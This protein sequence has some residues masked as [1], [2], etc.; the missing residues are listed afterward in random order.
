MGSRYKHLFTPIRIRGIDL[1]NRIIMAPPSPNVA[2]HEGLVTRDF[3]D[4]MRP[5]ARGGAAVIY[6]GNASIDR[7]ECFDEDY[8]LDLREDKSILPLSWYAEMAAQYGCHASLEINHNGK[9]TAPEAIGRPPISASPIITASEISRAK[10]LGRDPIPAIEMTHEKIAETVEKYAMAA[11]RMQ[12][13]GMNICLVHGGHGNL[14]SQFTSP[15]YNKRTDEYGG[16]LE[17]RA[18]FAIEVCKAIR[19]KCGPNF[20]ID[21]RIS[22]DEIAPEGMHFPETLELIG[23]LKDYIDMLN[24][25]AGL[26]SDF[27]FKYYRNW[28]QN[29]MMERGYNV[30]YARKIKERYPDLLVTAVGSIVSIDMVEEIIGNGWA[31][32]VA[33][34]RPLMADPEM[35]RKYALGRPEDRR[36]CLRCDACAGRLF[37]SRPLNCAVN[38]Y[39]GMVFEF[40]DGRVPKAPVKK[41]V[42]VVGGGPAGIQAMLALCERGHDVTLY[43]KS[44]KLG[45]NL[46]GAAVPSFKID[47]Q[48]YRDWLLRQAEKAPARIL[49]NTEATKEILEK[50]DYDAIIIAVGAKPVIPDVPGIDKPHVHWAPDAHLGKA[51]VGEKIAIIGAGAIGVETAIDFKQDGKDVFLIEIQGPETHFFSLRQSAGNVSTEQMTYIE[52]L[53]IPLHYETRLEEVC[54]DK[55]ICRNV[56]TGETV[57]YPCDTVLLAVGMV[58]LYDVVDSLRRCAPETEVHIVGDARAVGNISTAVNSAFQ[59]VVHI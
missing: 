5:F 56:K 24:V 28:C 34:C 16:S 53:K 8:Q 46:I 18:R 44:D 12:Q 13:A 21:F 38:P 25:S 15:L 57:E 7:T 4:W 58:P 49:L 10:R 52:N 48:D 26:H 27:D 45:G 11:Y 32:F 51:P 35:P 17:N 23:I 20:I 47:F 29:Y 14:I 30:H 42:A 19:E 50:E 33:M 41:K 1:K 6:V 36:P 37:P 31:D 9:D 54:D 22:A 43:E 39:L 3:V 2:S 55:I 40:K 59:A